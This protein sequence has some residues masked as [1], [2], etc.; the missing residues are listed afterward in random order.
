LTTDAQATATRQLVTG[1]Y[2]P[3]DLP[4]MHAAGLAAEIAAQ[5]GRGGDAISE[6]MQA[7]P[8]PRTWVAAGPL[9]DQS[10]ASLSDRGVDRLV[11]P[12]SSL[13]SLNLS[14]TLTQP[15]AIEARQGRRVA[16]MA[17]DGGLSAHF[18]P[19]DNPV[20]AAQQF[21]ADLAV[22]YF[23]APGSKTPRAIVAVPGHSWA[24]DPAFL[25]TA[26]DG[27]TDSPVLAPMTLD[28]AFTSVP[29]A[30][31]IKGKGPLLR[32]LAKT[33]LDPDAALSGSSIRTTRH[34]LDAFGS[35]L[36]QDNQASADVFDDLERG[37][38]TAESSDIR[39]RQHGVVLDAVDER[40][41]AQLKLVHMPANRSVRLTARQGDIPITVLS[42]APYP[43]HVLLVIE[44]TDKLR[45][46]VPEMPPLTRRA[47]I[48]PLGVEAR[49]SGAFPLKVSIESPAEGMTI[50]QTHFTVRSTA[51]SGV[52]IVLSAGAG[53]FL[54][55]WWVRNLRHG[56]RA[57]QLVPA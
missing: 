19:T 6:R 45:F 36:E 17:A 29:A 49:T 3:I 12:E 26:L 39:G 38:L 52:G 42:D 47:T 33:P 56:R 23:D 11:L 13:T 54:L 21:L 18:E 28:Q 2:V 57:R 46:T 4:A 27:L 8:D 40:I 50:S 30:T 20:L 7:R 55:V 1:P 51:A 41:D 24:S 31:A 25:D 44:R 48:V 16:T 43:L 5:A 34:R 10:V 15:F 53:L 14:R 35:M 22:V 32:T 37:L 9:D